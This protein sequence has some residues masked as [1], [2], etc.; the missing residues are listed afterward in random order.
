M[1]ISPEQDKVYQQLDAEFAKDG[2]VTPPPAPQP[3]AA[4]EGCGGIMPA[5]QIPCAAQ[6]AANACQRKFYSDVDGQKKSQ[7]AGQTALAGYLGTA[8]QSANNVQGQSGG[9]SYKAA[10]THTLSGSNALVIA[11][12]QFE[13]CQSYTSAIK[14]AWDAMQKECKD[15]I[16]DYAVY[17]PLEEIGTKCDQGFTNA[18]AQRKKSAV[19]ANTLKF[20]A[21]G[22]AALAIGSALGGHKKD[23]K[24]SDSASTPTTP[25]CG[26]GMSLVDNVCKSTL[27][28]GVA[29]TGAGGPTN[30]SAT[31]LVTSG[32][33]SGMKVSD[34]APAAVAPATA[35]ASGA[36]SGDAQGAVGRGTSA[37]GDIS[38]AADGR[39][40]ASTGR[41]P[42]TGGG[43]LSSSGLSSTSYG[44]YGG[45]DLSNQNGAPPMDAGS[46][47][48]ERVSSACTTTAKVEGKMQKVNCLNFPGL[49]ECQALP[50]ACRTTATRR[51][52]ALSATKY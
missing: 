28:N 11:Q 48:L 16:S 46:Q 6:P 1:K 49:K 3:K 39:G 7:E 9:S 8:V 52:S 17:K 44:G 27:V 35:L 23:D 4:S 31:E 22:G 24:K 29:Q 21:V 18:Q 33:S 2:F 38:V 51:A 43:T 42:A 13:D 14:T 25:T 32:T 5:S 15:L 36:S 41:A 20:G 47:R 45:G 37:G 12:T 50:V 26:T 10:F 34:P 19:I 30:D 40:L